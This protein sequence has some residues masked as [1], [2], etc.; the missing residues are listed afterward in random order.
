MTNA[1]HYPSIFGEDKT[2][3][4]IV[5]FCQAIKGSKIQ[6]QTVRFQIENDTIIEQKLYK[7]ISFDGDWFYDYSFY[8]GI[9]EDT[10]E[11]KVY[12][13]GEPFGE[14][15]TC[16]FSLSVGDTF[17]FPQYNIDYGF[18]YP[19]GLN[20]S[21]GF[22]IADSI[23]SFDGK[24]TITFDGPYTVYNE[25]YI[26]KYYFEDFGYFSKVAFIEGVGPNYGPLDWINM[27]QMLLCVHKDNNVIY[28]QRDDLGCEYSDCG[29][30][31]NETLLDRI[32]IFPNPTRNEIR[33]ESGELKIGNVEIF[34]MLGRKQ[35]VGAENLFYSESKFDISQLPAGI[36]FV[37]IFTEAGEVIKKILKE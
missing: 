10:I 23:Y 15:L 12:V 21:N 11:G 1:Q 37:K 14:I 24:R 35:N 8:S 20:G 6:G 2:Q 27:I 28:V 34:D 22:M 3:F 9:R 4:N 7:K 32:K 25:I 30:S 26:N 29:S 13:Y 36:Y 5:D 18:F 16:D 17:F 19:S 33:I 31:V